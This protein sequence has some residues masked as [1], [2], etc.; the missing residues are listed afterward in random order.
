MGLASCQGSGRA[1]TPGALSPHISKARYGCP[2]SRK[3]STI[4]C[5][6]PRLQPP[7]LVLPAKPGVLALTA[8][9]PPPLHMPPPTSC[10]FCLSNN[11]QDIWLFYSRQTPLICI[12]ESRLE[13]SLRLS[14]SL[15]LRQLPLPRPQG[16]PAHFQPRSKVCPKKSP[17]GGC[18]GPKPAWPSKGRT[19]AQGPSQSQNPPA[20]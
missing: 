4:P 14:V 15:L 1:I 9:A 16:T 6:F 13:L 7:A 11:T 3:P 5:T 18:P 17:A 19:V 10:A 2:S 8:P 20:R 12:P